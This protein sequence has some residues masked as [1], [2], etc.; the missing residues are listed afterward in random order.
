LAQYLAYHACNN[1][2]SKMDMNHTTIALRANKQKEKTQKSMKHTRFAR[3]IYLIAFLALGTIDL[4]AQTAAVTSTCN[5][6]DDQVAVNRIKDIITI[7]GTAGDM[8]WF[9]NYNYILPDEVLWRDSIADNSFFLDGDVEDSQLDTFIIGATGTV[10][11]C[12]WRDPNI[13][14]PVQ[15][16]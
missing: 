16:H 4:N 13:A 15:L 11:I 1:S 9:E 5:C 2:I 10:D 8:V 3:W 12:V 14:F 7:T 6:P